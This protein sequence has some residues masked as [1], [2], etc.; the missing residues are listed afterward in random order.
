[1]RR[2]GLE[3]V[4]AP[5]LRSAVKHTRRSHCARATEDV[6]NALKGRNVV[7]LD[8]AQGNDADL[9]RALSAA[10]PDVRVQLLDDLAAQVCLCVCVCALGCTGLWDAHQY[11][12]ACVLARPAG[13]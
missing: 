11:T 9:L 3:R 1:V 7:A 13:M 6:R 5:S 12:H 10:N 4:H 8:V 2:C